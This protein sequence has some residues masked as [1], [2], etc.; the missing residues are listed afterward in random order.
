MDRLDQME[1]K[2]LQELMEQEGEEEHQEHQEV[3]AEQEQQVLE[4]FKGQQVHVERR[5]LLD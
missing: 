4:D 5:G 3:M 2:G 1:H